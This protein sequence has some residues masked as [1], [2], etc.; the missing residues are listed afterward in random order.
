MFAQALKEV[1]KF[2]HPVILM[3]RRFDGKISAGCASFVVLNSDGW[4]ITAAH[5]LEA[6]QFYNTS[7]S[8]LQEYQSKIDQINA[9]PA[10]DKYKKQKLI[11]KL[12]VNPNWIT[13]LSFWWGANVVKINRFKVDKL[14]D[15]A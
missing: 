13:N 6:A 9:D 4:I 10:I 1:H 7:K 11:N 3:M 15:I 8:Q 2:T 5:V 12:P 14:R